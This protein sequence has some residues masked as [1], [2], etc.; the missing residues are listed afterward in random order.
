MCTQG[1]NNSTWKHLSDGWHAAWIKLVLICTSCSFD[2]NPCGHLFQ[3]RTW[4]LVATCKKCELHP[5][6]SALWVMM[7]HLD[8]VPFPHS[9]PLHMHIKGKI[10]VWVLWWEGPIPSHSQ[11]WYQGRCK[12]TNEDGLYQPLFPLSPLSSDSAPHQR[13][14]QEKGILPPSSFTNSRVECFCGLEINSTEGKGN[15]GSCTHLLP[16]ARGGGDFRF[17]F[18]L[19]MFSKKLG[20]WEKH[21][22]AHTLVHMCKRPSKSYNRF[23]AP[24]VDNCRGNFRPWKGRGESTPVHQLNRSNWGDHLPATSRARIVKWF[25]GALCKMTC[26]PHPAGAPSLQVHFSPWTE[27]RMCSSPTSTTEKLRKATLCPVP[28]QVQVMN[29]RRKIQNGSNSPK[30]AEHIGRSR[31]EEAEERKE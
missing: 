20:S 23:L 10:N 3:I 2:A 22:H 11:K 25:G 30:E 29:T 12:D 24:L 18:F 28:K 31:R 9:H 7:S 1:E 16:G 13:K 15:D 14:K 27:G 21:M 6:Q 19:I 8:R 4:I 17:I 26:W 5:V